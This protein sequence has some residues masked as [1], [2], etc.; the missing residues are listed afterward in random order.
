MFSNLNHVIEQ[1]AKDK[2]IDKAV[3]TEAL[4][5]AMLTAAK[6]RYGMNAEIK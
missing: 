2:G 3:L 5:A 4:E 6:K 1:V